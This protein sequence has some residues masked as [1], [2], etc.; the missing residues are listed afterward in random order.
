[1]W[2]LN[3]SCHDTKAARSARIALQATPQFSLFPHPL[4]DSAVHKFNSSVYN[5][6]LAV[7]ST[8]S[9]LLSTMTHW[10]DSA[11]H[12][13]NSCLYN[14]SLTVQPQAQL[15]PLHWFTGSAVHNSTLTYTMSTIH[16]QC[17]PQVNSCLDNAS[18]TGKRLLHCMSLPQ[19]CWAMHTYNTCQWGLSE[20]QGAVKTHCCPRA[21]RK[22]SAVIMLSK[23]TAV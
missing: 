4:T 20:W 18:L 1:M 16:W 5:D 21:V 6:S 15:L 3:L 22:A 7:Q 19:H 17:S 10:R 23:H 12:K 2:L 13:F 8:S 11:V 9:T 14:D